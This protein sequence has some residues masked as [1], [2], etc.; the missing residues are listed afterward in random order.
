LIIQ[1]NTLYMF[2]FLIIISVGVV[3]FTKQMIII[4]Y[5]F[6]RFIGSKNYY[7]PKRDKY[8]FYFILCI[9]ILLNSLNYILG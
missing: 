3:G 1:T 5:G 7:L 4:L 8:L 9:L 2:S 6:P